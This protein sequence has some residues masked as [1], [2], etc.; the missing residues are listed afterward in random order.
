MAVDPDG[1][2]ILRVDDKQWPTGD[3]PVPLR[4]VQE[5]VA[6]E[7]V[8]IPTLREWGTL[9]M[10]VSLLAI[11]AARLARRPEASLTTTHR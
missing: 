5:Y 8:A 3:P 11:G 4:G 6:V 2:V 1:T 10:A 7:T 9:L